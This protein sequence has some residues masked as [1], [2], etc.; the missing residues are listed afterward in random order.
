MPNAK[1]KKAVAVARKYVER[2]L[3]GQK[4]WVG[5]LEVWNPFVL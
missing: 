4:N 5:E 3:D 2:M 1:A